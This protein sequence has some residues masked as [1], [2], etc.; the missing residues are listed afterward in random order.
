MIGYFMNLFLPRAGEA[1]RAA[2]LYRSDKVPF[3]QGLR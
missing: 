1:S 3:E 2:T